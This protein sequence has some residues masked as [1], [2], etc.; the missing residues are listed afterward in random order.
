M[1]KPILFSLPGNAEL[2]LA[3]SKM[4]SIEMGKTEFRT[5][6]DRES[7]IRIHSQVK[8]KTIILVCTLA[9]PNSKILPLLFMAST[10]KELGAKRICLVAPYLAYMRQDIRFHTG[11]AITSIIF[12]QLLSSYID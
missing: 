7:Y 9:K 2:T 11:E 5:F 6:P 1:D 3:L 10:I 12:A 8:N 4:L